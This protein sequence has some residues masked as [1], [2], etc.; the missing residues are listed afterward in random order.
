[1]TGAYGDV[2]RIIGVRDVKSPTGK[3]GTARNV[4]HAA[5]CLASDESAYVNAAKLVV[6]GGL[7]ATAR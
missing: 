3:M 4:A 7:T 1:M 6:D 5:L 2:E